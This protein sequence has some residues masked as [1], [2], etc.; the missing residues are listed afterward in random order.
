MQ[1]QVHEECY[2][3]AKQHIG[4]AGGAAGTR[5][6]VGIYSSTEGSN[7]ERW[8]MVIDHKLKKNYN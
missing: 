5:Q 2:L 8:Q 7:T 1:Q 3:V 6:V 4:A